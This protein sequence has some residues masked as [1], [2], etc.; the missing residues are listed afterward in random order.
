MRQ[1]SNCTRH[2]PHQS[3]PAGEPQ[4]GQTRGRISSPTEDQKEPLA[5][6]F[7][8]FRFGGGDVSK[9]FLNIPRTFVVPLDSKQ[10]TIGGGAGL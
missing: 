2:L 9:L 1:V 3:S 8:V 4:S 5:P 10:S 6:G 7:A